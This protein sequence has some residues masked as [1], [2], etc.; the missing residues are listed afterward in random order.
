MSAQA[1]TAPGLFYVPQLSA[2]PTDVDQAAS[3]PRLLAVAAWG[4]RFA[5]AALVRASAALLPAQAPRVPG[6]QPEQLLAH[7]EADYR[8]WRDD[9]VRTEHRYRCNCRACTNTEP[10]GPTWR[11]TVAPGAMSVGTK[12]YTRSD[13]TAER[14]AEAGHRDADLL[15]VVLGETGELP[16]DPPSQR[17][18]TQWSRKSRARMTRTLCELDYDPLYRDAAGKLTG[19]V[20][21]MVTLTYP[22][23]WLTV[24][25]DGATA[26]KHL[27]AL[28]KRYERAWGEPPVAIWKQEFQGRGAPHFH[29]LMSPPHGTAAVQ[30]DP[31]T[32]ALRAGAGRQ[33]RQWL[34]EVWAD[35]VDHPDPE[36][37]ARHL[38][39]GTGVDF[40][41][42]LRASDPKRVAV[43]FLKHNVAGDKEYQHVVPPEWQEP[44]KGPGRFWGYWGLSKAVAT[45]EV[46]P[47]DAT[48]AARVMR[49]WSRAQGRTRQVTKI[50]VEQ[51]TGRV[52]YRRTRTRTT[53]VGRGRGWI[54]L[55]DGPA[56]AADLAR[57]LAQRHPQEQPDAREQTATP[58]PR[59][60]R[61]QA[62]RSGP[63]L[64]DRTD[65][66]RP[67]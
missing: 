11:I 49:R 42:G 4:P 51:A 26:K 27:Q 33:F 20:P 16:E 23:D 9:P 14:Q 52:Y 28:A 40:A 66:G 61:G 30:H 46:T 17:E 32:G 65:L 34:S 43:Y 36:Q 60:R 22:G 63:D 48:A 55:N 15:A 7:A 1:T 10:E 18:I 50:R 5:S 6:K 12:D 35:V 67:S 64:R 38:A 19:R 59:A 8:A 21:A 41:E 31:R 45:V 24:A 39:A 53:L 3:D 13:R 57:Y 29:L 2:A 58:S 37:R 47:E 54:A 44:G 62:P 56:F 25:P